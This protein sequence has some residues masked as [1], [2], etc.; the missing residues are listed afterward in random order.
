MK[1]NRSEIMKKAW[2]IFREGAKKFGECLKLAWSIAKASLNKI[3]F[4]GKATFEGI[5]FR[6][7]SNYGKRRIYVNSYK[8]S[9]SGYID[10]DDHNTLKGTD[11]YATRETVE[12]F[13]AKYTIAC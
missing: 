9:Y 5:E 10:L 13:L 4:T 8:K 3:A 12:R 7:W 11:Y 2:A 1:Y 6:I